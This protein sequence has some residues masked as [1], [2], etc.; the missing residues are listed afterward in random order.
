M[1]SE[2]LITPYKKTCLMRW[3]KE[4]HTATLRV[5]A[6]RSP[7]LDQCMMT[8]CISAWHTR[9]MRV[10]SCLIRNSCTLSFTPPLIELA[11]L[12]HIPCISLPT[13]DNTLNRRAACIHQHEQHRPCFTLTAEQPHHSTTS[14]I[15]LEYITPLLS[16][17][18]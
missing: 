13:S 2:H 12:H 1:R 10:Q 9:D 17:T 3:R 14:L 8:L 4:G 18:H 11:H 16:C 7:A 15:S 6:S 5:V